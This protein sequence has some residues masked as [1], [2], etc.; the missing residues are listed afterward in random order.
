MRI[1]SSRSTMTNVPGLFASGLG[2]VGE[3][4]VLDRAVVVV[5]DDDRGLVARELLGIEVDERHD[6]HAVADVSEPRRSTVQADLPLRS[7]D[8]V[9][10]EA[11]AVVEVIDRDLL[12]RM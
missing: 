11:L 5:D 1:R 7:F 6:D 2:H 12:V 8:R 3:A 9:R 4:E 10:L